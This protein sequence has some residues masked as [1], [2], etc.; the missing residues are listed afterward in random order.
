[1]ELHQIREKEPMR[2]REK[3]TF[4]EGGGWW[5][6]RSPESCPEFNVFIVVCESKEFEILKH[7]S[8]H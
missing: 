3:W 5:C 4:P 7:N 8:K 2:Y 1:M 6:R